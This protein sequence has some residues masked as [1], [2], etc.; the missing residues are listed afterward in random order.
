MIKIQPPFNARPWILICLTNLVLVGLLGVLMRYKI[1]FEFPWFYQK[2]LQHGHS[3][4]AFAGWVSLLLFT[5]MTEI[6]S[7]RISSRRLEFYKWILYIQF[8]SALGMLVSFIIQGYA[9]YSLLF[10]TLNIFNVLWFSVLFFQDLKRT[11]NLYA[12]AWFKAAILFHCLSVLGT[13]ALAIMMSTHNAPQHPYLASVYWYLHFQYNGWFF[14]ALMGLYIEEMCRKVSSFKPDPRVFRLFFIS[15]IPAYGLSVL[16]LNL[17]FWLFSLVVVATLLQTA[18]LVLFVKEQIV[19]YKR[20]GFNRQN[21]IYYLLL[22]LLSALLI[23]FA[24]QLGS[25]IPSVSRLAF[26]FR[27][28]VIAYL[29]L[30]LLGVISVGLIFILWWKGH[31]VN[32]KAMRNSVY[33]FLSGIFLNEVVLAV[34]GIASFS[35]TT[36]PHVNGLLVLISLVIWI[37]MAGMTYSAFSATQRIPAN[38][39]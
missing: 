14:F 15:C 24:L 16:W 5:L 23:K 13:V 17:P 33:I 18:G 12:T 35:Y 28:I 6:I 31:L 8:F 34:Q 27:H 22:F 29:H 39:V 1:G 26:G 9:F 4:F 36:V 10:S 7:N 2:N 30:V 38:R 11:P 32:T 3:H 37:G 20:V 21:P 19:L 25:V